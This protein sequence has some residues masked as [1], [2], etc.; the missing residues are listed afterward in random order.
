MM[1]WGD[2]M[3]SEEESINLFKYRVHCFH[4]IEKTWGKLAQLGSQEEQP[5]AVTF[6]WGQVLSAW[7]FVPSCPLNEVLGLGDG[8][9]GKSHNKLAPVKCQ[10]KPLSMY[11]SYFTESLGTLSICILHSKKES[12]EIQS[13][14][15]STNYWPEFLC[16]TL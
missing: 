10:L 1:W 3:I 13:S 14:N 5:S 12:K 7:W 11:F 6:K 15:N 16:F 8:E 9:Y 4:F 2:V